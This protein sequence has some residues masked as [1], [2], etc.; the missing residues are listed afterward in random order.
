MK[1]LLA[2]AVVCFLA[3]G[4]FAQN[5]TQESYAK[6]RAVLDRSIGAYGGLEKLRAIDNFT[7]KAKGDRIQR[8]QSQKTFGTDRIAYTLEV[9]ADRRNDRFYFLQ[10]GG[11]PGGFRYHSG[12][13]GNKGSGSSFD[14][15]RKTNSPMPNVPPSFMRH[16]F[17]Y[18]PQYWVQNAAERAMHLRFIAKADIERRPHTAISYANEDGLEHTLFFDDQTSLV[19]KVERL[20]TDAFIGDVVFETWFTGYSPRGGHMLP[21]A[22]LMKTSGELTEEIRFEEYTVNAALTD[23]RFKAPDGFTAPAPAP[24]SQPFV[25]YSDTVYTVNAGGYNVLVVGFKDH[26]FVMETPANDRVS[27]QAIA[28]VKKLFPGKPIKYVAVTH[29]HDDHAGGFRTY[30]AEGATLL[31]LP[32]E[33]TFFEKVVKS[34]FTID[35][36]ALT[37]NPQ[38]LKWEAI[39]KGKRVLTDG[40]TTVELLDIGPG[41][42]TDE[43]LVAWL[44]NEKLVFQGDLLNRPNNNDPATI[45]ATTVHFANWLERSKLPV[46]RLIGVHG[47]PSTVEELRQG[48]ATKKGN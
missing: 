15:L 8:N 43:M 38:P 41:G 29:H 33:K 14:M 17:R 31:G 20:S 28:E 36:D 39:E 24:P 12:Q 4:L 2:V 18:L 9:A 37:L 30:V 27:R 45:N 25:K 40:T 42:H 7:F 6:A 13:V 16:W 46:E 34:T 26:V 3:Q 10:D 5:L 44:P 48:V 22:R 23:D 35:P 21:S 47:P 1:R 19:T 11:Y 32:G